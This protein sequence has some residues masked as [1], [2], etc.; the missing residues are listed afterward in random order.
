[1]YIGSCLQAM[2][3]HVQVYVYRQLLT[4]NVHACSG[5]YRYASLSVYA[6]L[7]RRDG[8]QLKCC[9]ADPGECQ[10]CVDI[11]STKSVGSLAME[12]ETVTFEQEEA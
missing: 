7:A 4:S 1:M 8:E 5:V 10:T 2:Y 6:G 3:M 12:E 9:K 11:S